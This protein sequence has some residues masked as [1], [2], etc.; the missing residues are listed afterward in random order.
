MSQGSKM[1]IIDDESVV[2]DMDI[3][4]PNFIH[5]FLWISHG[6]NV[7]AEN[8]LYKMKTK[9]RSIIMYSRPFNT[10][11]DVQLTELIL[12]PCE[13]ILG[14]CPYVPIQQPDKN[15]PSYVYLPPILFSVNNPEPVEEIRTNTGLYYMKIESVSQDEISP[16]S[17]L[18]NC[19]IL[20]TTKIYDYEQL[21]IPFKYNQSNN[22]YTYSTIFRM[23]EE[24]CNNNHINPSES[25]LGLFSCQSLIHK[26][27]NKYI[28]DVQNLIPKHVYDYKELETAPIIDN[29]QDLSLYNNSN[30][31]FSNTI[32]RLNYIPTDWSALAGLKHQGCA[33]NV[34][35]FFG[36]IPEEKAREKTVCLDLNGTSI[37]KIIDYLYTYINKTNSSNN[38]IGFLVRRL[39]F[40]TAINE[41]INFIKETPIDNY[42]M[43]FKMYNIKKF[44]DKD[45]HRGHTVAFYCKNIDSNK[46]VITYV[47]PQLSDKF[48]FILD[49]N[50]STSIIDIFG[51]ISH[52]ITSKY[53]N[54]FNFIDIIYTVQ[55]DFLKDRVEYGVRQIFDEHNQSHI[56]KRTRDITHG[57]KKIQTHS[58]KIYLKKSSKL[59]KSDKKKNLLKKKLSKK[60]KRLHNK[61]TKKKMKYKKQ[62]G[63]DKP[64]PVD[65]KALMREID[66]KNPNVQTVL[67]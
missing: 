53:Q 63:G 21:I 66:D 45:N 27:G 67:V 29:K 22:K 15:N 40:D 65:F 49:I 52:F 1:D 7:S 54:S 50:T 41:M 35:S 44:N 18:M 64:E 56:I 25:L 20:E 33:L 34:L 60:K 9:F 37:F 51:R 30:I 5:F 11:T 26:Y 59:K 38:I 3:V 31:S 47:D 55:K 2:S 57:G 17:L 6:G 28:Q 58:K 46:K 43:I 19:N 14:S 13:L 8:N 23:V 61:K 12:N 16:T 48:D 62:Y 4:E 36:I 42:C 24:Y 32:I 10:A 39:P